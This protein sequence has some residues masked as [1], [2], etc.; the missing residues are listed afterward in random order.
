MYDIFWWFYSSC[1]RKIANDIVWTGQVSR[2]NVHKACTQSDYKSIG[3]Q[4]KES[5]PCD[6]QG[7][8]PECKYFPV[9][10]AAA[11][12][13]INRTVL[14]PTNGFL[15]LDVAE[16]EASVGGHALSHS[17]GAAHPVSCLWTAM[18]Q[19]PGCGVRVLP[20]A[21]VGRRRV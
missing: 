1:M 2:A 9:Y 8:R 15:E 13:V 12:V 7:G 3:P 21:R 16:S 4:C 20:A 5:R 17:G 10:P 11:A 18:A 6:G 19:G 14:P